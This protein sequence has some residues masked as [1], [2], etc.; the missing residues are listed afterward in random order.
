VSSLPEAQ[1]EPGSR[2]R[3]LRN[4]LGVRSAREMARLESEAL[5]RAQHELVDQFSEDHRFRAED[6]RRIHK[7][8]LGEIYS[9]AGE[10][11]AVNVPKGSFLF[12]EDSTVDDGLRKA[13]AG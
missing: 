4:L 3:V 9:W 2:G 6:L 5:I 8:W 12:A 10:Y 7:V 1:F 11:R 13:R